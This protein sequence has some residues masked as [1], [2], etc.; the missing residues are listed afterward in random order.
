MWKEEMPPEC[1]GIAREFDKA[2]GDIRSIACR[3]RSAGGAIDQSWNCPAKNVFNDDFSPM[4][5]R[6]EEYAEHLRHVASKIRSIR[7]RIWVSDENTNKR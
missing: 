5:R 7:I 6:L 1:E 3:V 2:S 4:P